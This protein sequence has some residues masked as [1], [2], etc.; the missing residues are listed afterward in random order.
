[1]ECDTSEEGDNEESI[2]SLKQALEEATQQKQALVDQVEALK[3]DLASSRAGITELWKISCTQVLEYD[4]IVTA[5][6]NKIKELQSRLSDG[7]GS[8]FPE[9]QDAQLPQKRLNL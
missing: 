1:M 4:K 2:Y 6:D 7:S 5:K 3:R 9:V 8:S